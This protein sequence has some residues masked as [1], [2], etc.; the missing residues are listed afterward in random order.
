MNKPR[1][2]DTEAMDALD[3]RLGSTPSP[4]DVEYARAALRHYRSAYNDVLGRFERLQDAVRV[5]RAA[6]RDEQE[7][8]SDVWRS[9]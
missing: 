3:E 4:K 6:R 5:W 2:F 1:R 9:L 7:A 8:A